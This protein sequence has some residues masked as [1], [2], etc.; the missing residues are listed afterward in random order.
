MSWAH[1]YWFD[2]QE[3]DEESRR[4]E[5]PSVP[6]TTRF[7]RTKKKRRSGLETWETSL[8]EM[9]RRARGDE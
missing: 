1:D 6:V 5:K 2:R 7:L 9:K 3:M 4:P 8:R